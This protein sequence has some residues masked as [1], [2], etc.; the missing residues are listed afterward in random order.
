M[1][2]IG[3]LTFHRAI[4]FGAVLQAY[5]L[6]NSIEKYDVMCEVIDYRCSFIEN[7]YKPYSL[8]NLPTLKRFIA[9]IVKN[10]KFINN[11]ENFE[12]FINNS[13]KTS[14]IYYTKEEL[15]KDKNKY[16]SY[17]VGSDQ[18]WNYQ[19]AEFDNTYFLNFESD[20]FKKNSYAASFGIKDIPKNLKDEYKKR[21]EN[22]KNISVREKEGQE[23]VSNILGKEVPIVLDPTL[24][25]NSDEWSRLAI[26][27]IEKEKYI[28]VYL[29]AETK[30]ILDIAR[31]LS[32]E[33]NLKIIY[34]NDKFYKRKKMENRR[35]VD[36]Y[37]WV[38]LFKNAS[39]IVTNSFHGLCFSIN[40]EKE[41]Y[42]QLLP[43]PAKVNS[44]LENI[45]KK[46]ELE[47][48]E[49]RTIKELY[50]VKKI[51]YSVVNKIL[52]QE[53]KCSHKYLSNII[54]SIK[55]KN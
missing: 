23:I 24:L 3:I 51:D 25:L 19:T 29:I 46:F 14:K 6:Q 21:L 4:N 27:P 2:K 34:I 53:R 11:R 36:I 32:K 13:L 33:N 39:F 18:I 9:T 22:F 17:I 20:N 54:I 5:A 35:K 41:F 49:I 8:K 50:K 15:E 12:K 30:E 1:I 48:R 38:T 40:F 10:G 47:D 37:E 43:E 55:D 26:S 52:E 28:L 31:K 42:M 16:N 44:R 7:Y 45:L